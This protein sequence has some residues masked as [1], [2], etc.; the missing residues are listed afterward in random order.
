M[1]NRQRHAQRSPKM[2]LYVGEVKSKSCGN[3]VRF[4]ID[5]WHIAE[6]EREYLGKADGLN[7]TLR[8]VTSSEVDEVTHGFRPVKLCES[9][10]LK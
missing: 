9:N 8:V 5:L 3:S 2:I 1:V 10:K 6:T 7:R 4:E